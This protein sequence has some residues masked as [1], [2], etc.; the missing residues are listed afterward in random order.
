MPG[1]R[2]AKNWTAAT[3]KSRGWTNALIQELLP[4]PEYEETES[5][6]RRIWNKKLVK[7]A[8]E[9]PR[10]QAQRIEPQKTPAR[11]AGNARRLLVQAWEDGGLGEAP[12][13]D[14]IL[15]KYIH[16]GLLALLPGVAKGRSLATSRAQGWL[17]EFLALEERETARAFPRC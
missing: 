8:E 3:L 16:Q 6:R 7:A 9:H 12:S 13:D 17:K 11:G 4:P 5:G 1:H 14:A 2:P 10:F 15:A